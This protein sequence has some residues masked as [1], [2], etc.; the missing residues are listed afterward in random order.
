MVVLVT[1]LFL[2]LVRAAAITITI[3]LI[4]HKGSFYTTL[5]CPDVPFTLPQHAILKLHI[6]EAIE[7]GEIA[8]CEGGGVVSQVAARRKVIV[9]DCVDKTEAD[10]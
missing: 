10:Q 4:L 7:K 5:P 8:S 9:S 6:V 2:E 1:L 3:R